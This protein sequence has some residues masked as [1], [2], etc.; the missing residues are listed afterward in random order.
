MKVSDAMVVA[1]IDEL[2]DDFSG[3]PVRMMRAAIERALEVRSEPQLS[4]ALR[5]VAGRIRGEIR[6][7]LNQ[8]YCVTETDALVCEMAA[9]KLAA[10]AQPAKTEGAE[11]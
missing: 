8:P 2:H 10:L 5:S 4:E 1:A 11:R 9:D 7:S 6:E 3:M